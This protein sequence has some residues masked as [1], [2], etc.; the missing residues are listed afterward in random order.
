MYIFYGGPALSEFRLAQTLATIRR[1]LPDIERI[2]CQRLYFVDTRCLLRPDSIHRL[3]TILR[4]GYH[5]HGDTPPP[6]APQRCQLM[7]VVPRLGTISPWSSKATNIL[8]NAGMDKIR[9]I[10]QGIAWTMTGA[11]SDALESIKPFLHDRMTETVLGDLGET[12]RLFRVTEPAAPEIIDVISEGRRALERY[13]TAM[14]LSLSDAMTEYLLNYYIAIGRNPTDAEVMMFAQVNS[15]HCRHNI[16]N[17]AWRINNVDQPVSLFDMIK[18]TL[19]PGNVLSAYHDNAAVIS[20]YATTQFRADST[21]HQYRDIQCAVQMLIKVETHNHPTAISPYAGAATGAGGEIRDAAATG[22]GGKPKAGLCGFSVSNL[23]IPGFRQAWETDYGKPEQLASALD[24]MLEGPIG[25]ASF[26]NEFGRPLLAGYFR[27]YE[28]AEADGGFIRGYHKPIMLAGGYGIID[29]DQ[30]AKR[31]IPAGA[32][33]VVLGGPAMLIGLGGGGASSV[34]LGQRDSELDFSSV[35][36]D[37]PEMERRCQEVIDACLALESDNP[38]LSIHDVGAGGLSNALA[39]LVNHSG[40]GAVL[41]LRAI[42]NDDP[43][44]SP[45]QIW[46]NEAQERYVLAIATHAVQTFS[47]LCQRE[48][49]PFAILGEATDDQRL[50]LNDASLGNRAVDLPLSMMFDKLPGTRLNVQTAPV[51]EC[52][53]YRTDHLDLNETIRR[54]LRLPTVAD[55]HFLITIGDR[56]VSG[57]VARDQMV[58]PWQ[59]PVADCAV[60]ISSFDA[61]TGEAMAIGER[62][63]VALVN[64]P[65][66]GRMAVGEALTNLAAARI[67]TIKNVVLSANWMAATGRHDEDA[68]LFS[69]VQAV[70]ELCVELGLCIPVG[71]DSLSMSTAWHDQTTDTERQVTAPLSLVV[72]A[73]APVVDV[74]QSLTPLFDTNAG[75]TRLVLIDLGLGKNRLGGSCLTQVYQTVAGDAPDLD[76]PHDFGIFFRAIQLLNEAGIILAY[77]DRSDGGLFVSICEMSFASRTGINLQLDFTET[78]TDALFNEELGAVLQIHADDW[79]HLLNAFKGSA[80]QDHIHD[81]GTLN[82]DHELR[83]THHETVIFSEDIHTLHRAWSET[84]FRMQALRDHTE[85]AQQDYDRLLNPDDTGLFIDAAFVPAPYV[86]TGA[87]PAVAIL[88]EQGINGHVEMAAAFHRAGFECVDVH[89]SDLI[90]GIHSLAAFKGLI[91]CGGFSYGDVLGAGRGWAN[92]VLF[93]ETATRVFHAFLARDDTFGLGVCNGCQMFS[94]LQE[95]IAG[96]A[97]WPKFERNLSE[98]FEARLVMVEVLDSPSILFTGM[99][100]ARL[101]IVVAHGEGRVVH[102]NAKQAIATLRYIDYAGRI[103]TTYPDNPNGSPGGHTG[104]TTDDGRFTILMPHPER[105]FLRTQ[106]SWLPDTWKHAESPWMQLFYNARRWVD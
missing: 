11:D 64:A 104:F 62:P 96:G 59:T 4:A 70:S 27:T 67:M 84:S 53:T 41:E 72:T 13:D 51:P 18:Q 90:A 45:M 87:K 81:I 37:N 31:T 78:A 42:P 35:Q 73:F 95:M 74:R 85:C 28:Q 16:F 100:G 52:E 14:G 25:A 15:E 40:R 105:L 57:L 101:P 10:E 34:R 1:T 32:K 106:Y 44:L 69:T 43:S 24:I 2:N 56:S 60:T 6:P 39:E 22:R 63:A 86:N 91:A 26:N 102:R 36:R 55:K 103:A 38:I 97:H 47:D 92:S 8:H 12:E 23:N 88:R 29:N 58:G 83:I 33:L 19:R 66:S 9:R 99:H 80:L 79:T 30:V 76:H 82:Q 65:A 68:H 17:A 5:E 71:K 75:D 93:N 54:I 50:I 46:C 7:L 3:A 77:H 49:A 98:Q 21:S 61:H 20:G 48:R 94:Y 89:M